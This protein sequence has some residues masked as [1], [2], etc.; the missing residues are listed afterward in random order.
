[1][2]DPT[3]PDDMPMLAGDWPNR[4]LAMQRAAVEAGIAALAR[5]GAVPVMPGLTDPA[6]LDR[7]RDFW[8]D[9]FA[10]WE[11]FLDP[12]TAPGEVAERDKRFKAAVWREHPEFDLMRRSY[13]LISDHVLRGID[14]VEGIDDAARERLRFAARGMLDAVSPANFALT[15]PEVI[16]RTIATGGDNLVK[17]MTHFL[18]DLAKGQMTHVAPQAFAL[19]R[20]L[21]TTPGKVIHRTPLY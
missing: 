16:E 19:G 3:S 10:L 5:P 9:G 20:N 2:A 11:R 1:M 6:T 18:G 12:A 14:A 17:G 21:A 13:D 8:R 4:M 7:A 15:N